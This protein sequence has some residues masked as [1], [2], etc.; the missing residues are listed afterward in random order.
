MPT[1][2]QLDTRLKALE[3]WRLAVEQ[4]LVALEAVDPVLP[5]VPPSSFTTVAGDHALLSGATWQDTIFQGFTRGLY[6]AG[7][8]GATLK[9]LRFE[10]TAGQG[11]YAWKFGSGTQS[12]NIQADGII[13]VGINQMFMAD[14]SDSTFRNMSI[15]A[16]VNPSTSN[17]ALYL[18]RDCHNLLFEN[19]TLSGGH[20]Q[21]LHLYQETSGWLNGSSDITFNGLTITGGYMEPI[22]FGDYFERVTVKNAK[23]TNTGS[24]AIFNFRRCRDILIDGFEAWGK[25]PLVMSDYPTEALR[26]VVRNG[27]YHGP[28][29]GSVP[30]VTFENVTLVP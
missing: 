11:V 28:S 2:T 6:G 29:L 24:G 12:I 16:W 27:V 21:V 14:V 25:G 30:G 18:E 7:I 17:H 1:T 26:I 22:V 23:L 20:G 19:L 4:R 13:A 8:N 10:G 3:A 9:N 5:P 15:N